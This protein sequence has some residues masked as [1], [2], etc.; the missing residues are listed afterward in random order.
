MGGVHH[1][2]EP[3]AGK[4]L[5][6]IESTGT[7]AVELERDFTPEELVAAI[8]ESLKDFKDGDILTGTIVKIDRDEVLVDIGYKSEGVI[9][10]KELS[11]RHDVDPSEV[12]TLGEVVEALVLQK[13]DKEGRLIL[14]KKRAQYERAWGRIEE[15]M[16]SGGTIKGPVI[17]VVKGC[18]ILDIGL[19]GFLPAS[20]VDLR[21]VRDLQPFVGQELEA[22]IIE[23]DRNRNNVVL[24][25]RAFLEESQSEGR[26]TF[27]Q[28]LK[29]G[30][31]RKGTVSSIVNFGAFVDLGGVDG[32]VHVSELSW[33]HVDHP[34]EVV[35][36]GQEVEVEVLDVDLDRERVS[37]SLKATQEDPW[38]EFERTSQAGAVIDGT[39]TKLVPFGAFV[40]VAQGIE[41]LVHISEISHEHVDAPESVLSV[42]QE[43]KVKVIDVDVSRRRVSLSMRQV[44][45]APPKPKEIEVEAEVERDAGPEKTTTIE[46]PAEILAAVAAAEDAA[47]AATAAPT[48]P[49]GPAASAP[50][51]PRPAAAAPAP[52]P[53]PEPEPVVA[54][55]EAEAEPQAVA[56]AEP[57]AAA[58]VVAPAEPSAAP[59]TPAPT[60]PEAA[61]EAPK[62]EEPAAEEEVSLEA[63]L[64][65]LKRRE[66]RDE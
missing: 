52:A 59:E 60:E 36:V 15:I 51:P 44:T 50:A 12:A 48:G 1:A 62:A 14:S 22:K 3:V 10:S 19:R 30:E 17:E 18:L 7:Q 35:S 31:R 49:A 54:A 23:L 4:G 61:P 46:G 38:K 66:G 58:T 57:E 39:V 26:K 25:R 28:N 33:K 64:Q 2:E 47:P 41:G 65:D 16:Q 34:Q 13:E 11:I 56:A 53:E 6:H 5:V 43:V 63:I 21:R 24:S 45:A 42:G 55:A 20:L 29:K 32:L 9:P 37:L 40:R 8:E 27:L